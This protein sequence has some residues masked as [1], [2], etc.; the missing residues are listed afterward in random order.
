MTPP[1][2]VTSAAALAA[3]L[4]TASACG[5]GAH[6]LTAGKYHVLVSAPADGG[7]DMGIS[8]KVQLVGTCLGIGNNIAFWPH[9]T[10]IVSEDPLTV[11]VPGEGELTIG[12][13]VEGAGGSHSTAFNPEIST[14]VPDL[15]IPDTCFA[16][17][18]VDFRSE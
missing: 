2:S 5:G 6:D 12:D 1:R 7:E 15:P 13:T 17:T 9:G 4:L 3:V 14:V 16:T 18:W 11:D 10:K 8:G